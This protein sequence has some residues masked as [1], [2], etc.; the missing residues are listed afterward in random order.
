MIYCC[1]CRFS[2]ASLCQHPNHSLTMRDPVNGPFKVSKPCREVRNNIGEDTPC[3]DFAANYP[4]KIAVV[5][6]IVVAFIWAIRLVMQI[7]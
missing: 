7:L 4:R 6:T 5:V 1:D 3:P 2:K